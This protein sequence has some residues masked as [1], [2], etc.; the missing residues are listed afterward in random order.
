MAIGENDSRSDP[1]V[2][3]DDAPGPPD[4]SGDEFESDQSSTREQVEDPA[5]LEDTFEDLANDEREE[6][7]AQMFEGAA[8][9]PFHER[10][11]GSMEREG[12]MA[13]LFQ[14][15]SLQQRLGRYTVTSTLGRG[16]MGTVFKAID[17]TLDRMVAIKVLTHSHKNSQNILDRFEREARIIARIQHPNIVR[18]YDYGAAPDETPYIVMELLDGEDLSKTLGR[19]QRMPLRATAPLIA[20]AARGLHAAHRAGI[21]H[22]DLKPANLFLSRELGENTLKVL[23]FGIATAQYTEPITRD[24]ASQLIGTPAYMS[25]EQVRAQKVDHRTDLWSLGVVAYEALTGMLPFP[26]QSILDTAVRITQSQPTPPSDLVESLGPAVDA[27]F[28]RALAKAPEDRFS[29]ALEFAAAFSALERSTTRP[30][31]VILAVDDEPDFESLIRLCFLRLI[32]SGEFEF[33]FARNGQEA[34]DRLA[35]RPDIE[36]VLTDLNMPVMDGLTLLGRLG[37]A[38]PGIRAVVL[39]AYDDMKNIRAAMNAGAYDFLTKPLDLADLKTTLR[40]AVRDAQDLRGALRAIEEN[41]ALRLFVDNALLDRLLPLLRISPEVSD[42]TIDAT[43]ASIDLHGVRERVERGSASAIFE[44]LNRS[45]D[46]IIPIINAWQG[47]VVSFIGDAALVVFHGDDHLERACNACLAARAAILEARASAQEPDAPAQVC[48]GLDAGSIISGSIGS[49]TIKRL[50][51]AVLGQ[52]VSRAIELEHLAQEGQFLVRGEVAARLV[53]S[54]ECSEVSGVL[55]GTEALF[56]V[57][58][59]RRGAALVL[60]S[61]EAPTQEVRT[62]PPPGSPTK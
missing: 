38:G 25:P 34:L 24:T 26:G 47:L 57:A 59:R 14:N 40:K 52:V 1:E 49:K 23:D 56:D 11:L 51:Y 22:R 33:I 55:L 5:P 46:I 31:A 35:L 27:F 61:E 30:T 17:H 36:V 28:E 45:F 6:V 39:T 53:P 42:E 8:G 41:D 16:G 9:H 29:S 54:F 10:A 44:L 7:L 62:A 3:H 13:R 43:I 50:S 32:R 21:V 58:R 4:P 15:P 60:A 18:V 48:I 19:T 12:M 20:Q 2:P 37:R